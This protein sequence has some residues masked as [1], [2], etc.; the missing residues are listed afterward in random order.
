VNG[1]T[2]EVV[3]K[4]PWSFWKITLFILAIASVIAVIGYFVYMN[5]EAKQPRTAEEVEGH[6]EEVPKRKR[7]RRPRRR[8]RV[9]RSA[10]DAF[11]RTRRARVIVP[12][13]GLPA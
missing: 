1:Q 4:A 12:E 10:P 3:G 13:V 2:G 11:S 7:R 6:E 8:R 9:P 5:Q